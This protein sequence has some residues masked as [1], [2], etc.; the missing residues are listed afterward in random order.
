MNE[1]DA[2]F[3][4]RR[5]F[6]GFG[7]AILLLVALYV[8]RALKIYVFGKRVR[9]SVVKVVRNEPDAAEPDRAPRYSYVLEYVDRGGERRRIDEQLELS[10]REFRVGDVVTVF[11][12][13]NRR[14]EILSWRRLI[15]SGAV[16]ALTCAAVAA[17][18]YALLIKKTG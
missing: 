13:R 6:L 18:Y 10:V 3:E 14:A 15:L 2:D 11:V 1:A 7:G 12:G 17:G 5:L 8:L 16:I 4:L 9:A